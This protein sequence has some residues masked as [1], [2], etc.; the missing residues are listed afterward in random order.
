MGKHYKSRIVLEFN[1]DKENER[2]T[3]EKL[4]KF[5]HPSAI[6]KDILTGQLPIGIINGNFTETLQQAATSLA[7][8]DDFDD[9]AFANLD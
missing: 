5:T 9:D 4:K 8:E 1:L 7:I 6:V 3:F 2:E